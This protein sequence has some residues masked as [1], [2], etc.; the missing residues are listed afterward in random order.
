MSIIKKL[1]WYFLLYVSSTLFVY[2]VF[3][4]GMFFYNHQD[5]NELTMDSIGYNGVLPYVYGMLLLLLIGFIQSKT[6]TPEGEQETNIY[7]GFNLL[8][9]LIEIALGIITLCIPN[10]VMPTQIS[11]GVLLA[12]GVGELT[13]SIYLFISN[14]IKPKDSTNQ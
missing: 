3:H 6:I 14:K 9:S 1:L 11:G 10:N 4:G 2:S 13:Y 12:F 8:F 7:A 5:L